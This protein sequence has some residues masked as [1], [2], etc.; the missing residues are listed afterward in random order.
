MFDI[1]HYT[2]PRLGDAHRFGPLTCG[3]KSCH[4]VWQT[5]A[6][7]AAYADCAESQTMAM[8]GWTN[9]KMPAHYI[10]Q[11]NREKLGLSGMEKIVTFDQGQ[12][13]DGFVPEADN[14]RTPRANEVV[15][16][17]GH[18]RKKV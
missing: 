11:A 9:P 10:A 17:P 15:T 1:L 4:G 2:F 7:V 6:E 12:L 18:F 13:R 5:R 14:V 3:Q 8:F 16:F